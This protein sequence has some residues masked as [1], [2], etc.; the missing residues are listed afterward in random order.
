MTS[1]VVIRLNLLVLAG[2]LRRIITRAG[3]LTITCFLVDCLTLTMV[4]G[5][6]KTG[7]TAITDRFRR[8]TTVGRC[9]IPLR[10]LARDIG[11]GR[12]L[13]FDFDFGLNLDLDLDLDFDPDDLIMCS[14]H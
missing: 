10:L 9:I 12:C 1:L 7:R 6:V 13:D 4:R 8:K 2:F 14:S 5:A 3:F 11:S